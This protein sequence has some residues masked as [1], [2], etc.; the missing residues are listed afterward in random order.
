MSPRNCLRM[1]T[2]YAWGPPQTA[3]GWGRLEEVA[4]SERR[5]TYSVTLP[6]T[7]SRREDAKTEEGA[8]RDAECRTRVRHSAPISDYSNRRPTAVEQP[9]RYE[10]PFVPKNSLVPLEVKFCASASSTV[11]VTVCQPAR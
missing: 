6:L 4:G 1:S 9:L 3:S 2:V 10:L 7:Q 8:D 11:C 5:V